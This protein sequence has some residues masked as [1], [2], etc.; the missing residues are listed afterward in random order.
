MKDF[1]YCIW[2]TPDP[3][4]TWSDFSNGFLPHLSIKTGLTIGQALNI[5]SNINNQEI[6]VEL[7]YLICNET[8]G[9]N[10]LYYTIKDKGINSEWWPKNPHIS[11]LYK[12]DEKITPYEVHDLYTNI[13]DKK[14][15]LK[16]IHIVKCIGHYSTWEIVSSK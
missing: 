5:F 4:H 2:Y 1:K 16:K 11:F 3:T 10:S 15:I 8:E 13:N 7:D 6:E 12:Y 14:A 9:F